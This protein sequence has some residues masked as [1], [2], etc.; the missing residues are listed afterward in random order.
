MARWRAP[1]A[2]GA[3]IAFVIADRAAA[4]LLPQDAFNGSIL[5]LPAATVLVALTAYAVQIAPAVGR[6]MMQAT[7]VF[8]LSLATR[9]ADQALCGSWAPGTH[10]IWHLL[11]AWVLYRLACALIG[12]GTRPAPAI[13]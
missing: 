9:T 10:F 1:L 5:Y 2:I 8:C 13:S 12:A 6:T 7:A 3:G 4:M 11:N